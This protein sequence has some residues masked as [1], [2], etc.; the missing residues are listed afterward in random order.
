MHRYCSPGTVWTWINTGE[1]CPCFGWKWLWE[2]ASDSP[3]VNITRLEQINTN[4]KRGTSFLLAFTAFT[5]VVLCSIEMLHPPVFYWVVY[6]GLFCPLFSIKML[7]LLYYMNMVLFFFGMG[8][9]F[10]D[11]WNYGVILVPNMYPG[12]SPCLCGVIWLLIRWRGGR[13]ND[14]SKF[15]WNVRP[16]VKSTWSAAWPL[17]MNYEYHWPEYKYVNAGRK[18]AYPPAYCFRFLLGTAL[19]CT[20]L[21]KIL[22]TNIFPWIVV[23]DNPGRLKPYFYINKDQ[24]QTCHS[25]TNDMMCHGSKACSGLWILRQWRYLGLGLK[26]IILGDLWALHEQHGLLINSS[27][28]KPTVVR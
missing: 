13:A 26:V 12:L 28:T 16:N 8:S 4:K 7:Q 2:P 3:T 23:C 21:K 1:W 14:S 15:V 18:N 9:V 22:K 6:A 24:R 11:S 5:A 25:I 20:C 27:K 17:L 19:Y 10:W